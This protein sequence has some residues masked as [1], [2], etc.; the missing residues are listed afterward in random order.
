DCKTGKKNKLFEHRLAQLSN[1]NSFCLIPKADF[2]YDKCVPFCNIRYA[3][4]FSR[5]NRNFCETASTNAMFKSSDNFPLAARMSQSSRLDAL[6]DVHTRLI[7]ILGSGRLRTRVF[8]AI[9]R[10]D[11]TRVSIKFYSQSEDVCALRANSLKLLRAC[12]EASASA[13]GHQGREPAWLTSLTT[14]LAAHR[15]RLR[16]HSEGGAQYT[17]FDVESVARRYRRRQAGREVWALGI[18]LFDMVCG[19]IPFERDDADLFTAGRGS[20]AV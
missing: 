9:R 6:H 16:R 14:R 11:G 5:N 3:A 19:D 15:L 18:L 13:Q 20:S 10:S 8:L 4:D 7:G 1:N 12:H 2:D 17:D